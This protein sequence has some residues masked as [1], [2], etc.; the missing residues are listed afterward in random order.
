MGVP[1]VRFRIKLLMMVVAFVA[2]LFGGETTR[3]RWV[4]MSSLYRSKSK[5][6][7]W[8]ADGLGLILYFTEQDSTRGSEVS[9]LKRDIARYLEAARKYEH[10]A[11]RPWLSVD[12]E[13]EEGP[14]YEEFQIACPRDSSKPAVVSYK[15]RSNGGVSQRKGS[16][17]R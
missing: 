16:V 2:L 15:L 14:R 3:R 7:H 11:S 1:Q 12:V 17:G 6:C 10:A 5:E 9:D 8:K 4:E 13:I